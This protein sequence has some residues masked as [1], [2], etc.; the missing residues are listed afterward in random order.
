MRARSKTHFAQPED[1]LRQPAEAYIDAADPI[2]YTAYRWS[3]LTNFELTI[4]RTK[5]PYAPGTTVCLKSIAL[6]RSS[7]VVL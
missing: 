6:F 4:K 7:D 1:A 2:V 3:L 5:S